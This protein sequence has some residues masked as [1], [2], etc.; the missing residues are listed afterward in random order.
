MSGTTT[1][2]DRRPLRQDAVRNRERLIVAARDT[3]H[4]SGLDAP[5]EEIARQAGVSAGTLYNRF[6]SRG[7][8]VDAALGPVVERSVEIAER[9]SRAEDP[10]DG[11]VTFMEQTCE[12]LAAERGYTD[13]YRT[14]LADTPVIDAARKRMGVFKAQIMARA[15][16]AGALRDDVETTDII[17]AFWGISAIAESTRDTAPDAWR[18]HLALVLDGLRADAAHPL[19]ATAL[20]TR[21]LIR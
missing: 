8:L 18:R 2:G 10:W 6:A 4:R 14:R 21:A 5:L 16:A 3:F 11:F 7:E 20:S 1:S 12:L 15:K 13:V 17:M 9:A 19:P